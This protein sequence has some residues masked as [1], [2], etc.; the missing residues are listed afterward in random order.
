MDLSSQFMGHIYSSTPNWKLAELILVGLKWTN[1]EKLSGESQ[2]K[3]FALIL[4]GF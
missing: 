3:A 1:T 4:S 2:K